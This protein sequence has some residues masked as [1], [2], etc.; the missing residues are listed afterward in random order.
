MRILWVSHLVPYPPIA[1][2]LSR[3]YHLLRRVAQQHEVHLLTFTQESWLRVAF[4]SVEKGTA[5]SRTA[6]GEFVRSAHYEPIP[7]EGQVAG[8]YRLALRSLW[9][10]CYSVKWL[11]SATARKTIAQLTSTMQFDLVHFDT[12][13]LAQYQDCIGATPSTLGHHNVESHMLLRRSESESNAL[14]RWYFRQEGRRLERYERAMGPRFAMHVTCSALDSERLQDIV[15]SVRVESVPNGVDT[16]Y[17]RPVSAAADNEDLVFVGTMNWYP[18]ADAMRFFASEVWPTLRVARPR[19]RVLI[20]GA[21]PPSDLVALSTRDERFRVLGFLDDIRPTVH[22]AALYVCPIRDGG[23]TKLKLL[24]A[25][26]MGKCVVAHPLACEGIDV[27]AGHDVCFAERPEDF[28]REIE[29]LLDSP[30]ERARIGRNARALVEASY[31][32]DAL[33]TAMC[34]AFEEAVR[35]SRGDESVPKRPSPLPAGIPTTP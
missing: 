27:T 11:A 16:E 6:L 20:G 29:R 35:V 2:V 33:G 30:S 34:R 18:N 14:K 32:Y 5:A 13:S 19:S 23:G 31:S 28:V 9:G 7:S 22:D 17:F 25:F 12:I 3:S 4:G 10:D 1:G 21:S 24:D 15:G 26:A 8:R